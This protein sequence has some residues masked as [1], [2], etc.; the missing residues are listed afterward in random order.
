[1]E[2][3]QLEQFLAIADNGT[4]REAA[5]KLLLTPPAL[6][7][8]IKKLERELGCRLFERSQNRMWLS[9]YGEIFYDGVK[10]IMRVTNKTKE[11]LEVE[12]L[13]SASTIRL[14]FSYSMLC[15]YE[16]PEIAH[17]FE[18]LRF[19]SYIT[20]EADLLDRLYDCRIDFAYMDKRYASDAF[21]AVEVFTEQAYLS[22]PKSSAFYE[23]ESVGIEE[24]AQE[25]LLLPTTGPGLAPWYEEIAAAA[26]VP[27]QGIQR[28]PI[29]DYLC[30]MDNSEFN[31]FTTSMML[32]FMGKTADRRAVPIDSPVASRTFVRLSRG[33]GDPRVYEFEKELN[34]RCSKII[35]GHEHLMY[36]YFPN[37]ERNYEIMTPIFQGASA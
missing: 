21:N 22:V 25:T 19:E 12:K 26:K 15:Q 5:E 32:S 18:N 7:K 9:R 34:E 20:D 4:M 10:E 16:T 24:L 8:S 36:L 2:Y 27:D 17:L 14:G 30:A 37:T 23:R 33:E 11:L 6:S 29:R 28:S 13:K 1:M 35:V 31:H 3:Y